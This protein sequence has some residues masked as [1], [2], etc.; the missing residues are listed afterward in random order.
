MDKSKFLTRFFKAVADDLE[1]PRDDKTGC[2]KNI[3]NEKI[4]KNE[5]G[6]NKNE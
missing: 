5:A 4:E 6:D 1:L 3:N 2:N